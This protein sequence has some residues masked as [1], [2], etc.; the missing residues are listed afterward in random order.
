MKVRS[1]WAVIFM[2][3]MLIVSAAGYTFAAPKEGH[4]ESV[5]TLEEVVVTATR[6]TEEIRKV[7]ANVSVITA[8]QIE[9]QAQRL[10]VEVLDKL[11]SI[12]FR[13]YSGNSSQ[14][15]IDT[16]GFGGDNPF[17]KTLIMLDGRR[18]NRPD[19]ASIN[20]LQI[21]LNN[22]ERIEV[23]RGASTCPLW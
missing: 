12:Q 22:I 16:R 7:P 17:G 11:E 6:D 2:V 18:L 13:S 14:A 15:F 1:K 19:M 9:N 10:F 20:W 8:E 3:S 4:Q 23:V 5:I 21:P